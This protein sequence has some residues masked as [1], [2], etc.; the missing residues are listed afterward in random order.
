M[1]QGFIIGEV[2]FAGYTVTVIKKK[3]NQNNRT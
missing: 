1:V 3:R 2:L